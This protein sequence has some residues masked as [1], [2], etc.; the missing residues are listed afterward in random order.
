MLIVS[1]SRGG[2]LCRI[3][4]PCCLGTVFPGDSGIKASSHQP[5]LFHGE[6]GLGVGTVPAAVLA[7]VSIGIK[8]SQKSLGED[9]KR[10]LL[11]VLAHG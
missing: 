7:A 9:A 5:S 4:C 8:A 10:A 6:S 2:R 1:H 11:P 3:R